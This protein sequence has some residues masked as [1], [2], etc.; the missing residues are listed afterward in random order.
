MVVIMTLSNSIIVWNCR[1]A[2]NK[3]CYRYTEFYIDMYKPTIFV[4]METRCEPNRLHNTLQKLGFDEVISSSN[5]G[6]AGGTLVAW[7]K[8]RMNI[9]LSAK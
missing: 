8:D 6:Y 3:A 7:H 4:V 5:M 1:G 9:T 2:A